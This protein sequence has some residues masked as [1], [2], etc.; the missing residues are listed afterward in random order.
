MSPIVTVDGEGTVTGNTYDKYGSTNPVVRRLMTGFH[1]QLDE[2]FEQAGPTSI[3]D[4]GCGWPRHRPVPSWWTRT[5][6]TWDR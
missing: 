1:A 4:V 2:L 6:A 3:L 5:P